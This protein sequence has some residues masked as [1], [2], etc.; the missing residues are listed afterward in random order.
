MG[1]LREPN[2]AHTVRG[3]DVRASYASP[4]DVGI[5][6]PSYEVNVRASYAS[7]KIGRNKRKEQYF[8]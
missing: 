5:A 8:G 3:N 2:A 4:Q 1:E 7:P 6:R